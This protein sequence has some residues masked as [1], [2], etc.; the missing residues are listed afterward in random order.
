VIQHLLGHRQIASTT[1][2][3]RVALNTIRQ[4]T[5]ND[6]LFDLRMA[7]CKIGPSLLR[8]LAKR[9]LLGDKLAEKFAAEQILEHLELW[10]GAQAGTARIAG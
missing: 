3:A 7:L 5:R 2:Y 6:L 1:R 4:S 9:R 10:A 8:D